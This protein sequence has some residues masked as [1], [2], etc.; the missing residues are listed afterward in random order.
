VS[1]VLASVK[2]FTLIGVEAHEV[3][4]EVDVSSGL[5]SFAIVGLPDAAVRESRERVRAAVLNSGFE[6]PQTR[7]TASLAPA[8]LRKAGPGFDLAIA[9]ALLVA[10]AQIPPAAVAECALAAELALDGSVRTVPGA[11]AMAERAG[12]LGLGRI[13][14]AGPSAVE[15]SLPG[16]SLDGDAAKVVPLSRLG[17]LTLLGTDSEPIFKQNSRGPTISD[18]DFAEDLADLRGQPVL[19]NALEIAAAGGHGTLIV[20]PPGAGKSLAAPPAIDHA[21]A[22]R[23]RGDRGPSDR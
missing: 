12:A 7:I 2:T 16:H 22:F 23:R 18:P 15:A 4:V 3:A 13:V 9:A 11:L 21:A 1:F 6:F 17:D 5:P 19:R 20:G 14:V 8:D 10:S